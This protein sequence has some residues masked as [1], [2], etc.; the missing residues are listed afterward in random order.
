MITR[1]GV[2][3]GPRPPYGVFTGKAQTANPSGPHPVG[4]ITRLGLH[5]G[6]RPLYGDFSGKSVG[7]D[8][9][10]VTGSSAGGYRRRKRGE[11][12]TTEDEWIAAQD[13]LTAFKALPD[14][15]QKIVAA[16]AIQAV[17]ASTSTAPA[18]IDAKD[19]LEEYNSATEAL[20]NLADLNVLLMGYFVLKSRQREEDDIAA[21]LMLGII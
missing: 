12:F 16:Q 21:M 4:H 10:I 20:A 9:D 17:E 13:E 11:R 1:L 2:H 14:M 8:P 18:V 5:G 6:P 15:G 7:P 3:G 19:A